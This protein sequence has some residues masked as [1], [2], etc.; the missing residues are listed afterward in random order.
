M[1]GCE[2]K[3][4]DSPVASGPPTSTPAATAP[5]ID[6]QILDFDGFQELLAAKKGKVVVVDAWSTSCPPCMKEFPNLVALHKKHNPEDLAC[7]S[8]SFDYEGI[9][10][11]EQTKPKVLDFLKSQGATFDNVLSQDESDVLYRKLEL[12]SVPAVF[13]YDRDG[14]LV[15][16]FDNE[17][18]ASEAEA[19][20][21]QQ[22]DELVEQ[23]LQ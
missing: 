6:L 14:K 20:T 12:A 23:L 21:Y 16:R 17:K 4:I 13:V 2:V 18:A 9:G 22:V 7:I 3:P 5:E 8:L 11:P 15:K 10:S 1:I 19:F